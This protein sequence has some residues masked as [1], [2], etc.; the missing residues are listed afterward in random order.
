MSEFGLNNQPVYCRRQ[1]TLKSKYAEIILNTSGQSAAYTN[2]EMGY[3]SYMIQ[4][5]FKNR[6]KAG[7]DCNDNNNIIMNKYL[8]HAHIARHSRRKMG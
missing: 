4:Y 3:N 6:K 2:L 8:R 1:H 7:L 5:L